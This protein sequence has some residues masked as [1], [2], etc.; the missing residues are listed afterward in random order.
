MKPHTVFL[1]DDH[2]LLL[3]ALSALIAREPDFRVVGS[4]TDSRT[5][6]AMV[7]HLK[8]DI[9]VLDM[10]VS[11][12][13]GI[14]LLQQIAE[15]NLPVRVIFLSATMEPSEVSEAL[16]NR[17]WGLL[18]KNMEPLTVI[19]CMR[20]VA[21]GQRWIEDGSRTPL[22][23]RHD[24]QTLHDS[25]VL[26]PR[27]AEI[28]QYVSLGFSNREIAWKVGLAEGTVKVHL[29]SMFQKMGVTNR[30]SMAAS[31]YNRATNFTLG[32]HELAS[33]DRQGNK[34]MVGI[35]PILTQSLEGVE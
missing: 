35:S 34:A 23:P 16:A 11:H 32:T 1:V 6:L 31:F 19:Q 13:G 4:S 2:P 18:L 20:S 9:M 28:A 29:H 7:R 14:A 22:P 17:I 24:G 5:T 15:A 25:N 27:E 33:M 8:P 12:L 30:T 10:H 21:V 26:T 3:I